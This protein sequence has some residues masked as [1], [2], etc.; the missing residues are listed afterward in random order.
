[1]TRPATISWVVAGILAT[2]AVAIGA[3]TPLPPREI[4]SNTRAAAGNA[5]EAADNT[6]VMASD[7]EHLATIAGNA[8]RQYQISKRL[9]QTQL[10]M[11]ESSRSSIE[12]SRELH[13]GLRGIGR[14]LADLL[15]RLRKIARYSDA[16]TTS[17][18]AAT[19]AASSLEATLERLSARFEAVV[20]ESRELNRKARGYERVAP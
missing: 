2:G 5:A 16:S 12:E 1:M 7:T 19:S 17:A 14:E 18:G 15:E 13:E 10:E 4:A 3:G 8:R 20:R 9:L 6:N 11:E